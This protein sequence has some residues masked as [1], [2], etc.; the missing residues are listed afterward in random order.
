MT[1]KEIKVAIRED[2]DRVLG[3]VIFPFEVDG[4][5]DSDSVIVPAG[6]LHPFVVLHTLDS[7]L[8]RP[9]GGGHWD[10]CWD[11]KPLYPEEFQQ[12]VRET[13]HKSGEG[14]TLTSM[15]VYG[16]SYLEGQGRVFCASLRFSDSFERGGS[17]K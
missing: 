4:Y 16:H 17:V 9:M 15:W 2:Y 8:E 11:V 6:G 10:P 3:K 1:A 14:A 7:D 5:I 12:L 13:F